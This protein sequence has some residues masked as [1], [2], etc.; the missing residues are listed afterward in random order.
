MKHI[1]RLDEDDILRIVQERFN[2]RKSQITA[3]YDVDEED[4]ETKFYVEIEKD[5]KQA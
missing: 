2:I 4:N 3:F 5:E 1:L